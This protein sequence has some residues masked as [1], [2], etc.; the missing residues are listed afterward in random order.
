MQ[1]QYVFWLVV[2]LLIQACTGPQQSPATADK[3]T[4]KPNIVIIFTD[5]QGYA[6][7]QSFGGIQLVTP[8][9][10]R[11]AAEG[12]KLT[13]FYVAQPVCSASRAALLTGSYPNRVG[14]S[15]AFMPESGKGLNLAETTLA[16][17]LQQAGYVTGHVGKWHLGDDPT[18][19]PNRQG[20]DEFF[21]IP[22][23]NDMWP[24]HPLQ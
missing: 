4:R 11:M 1:R 15:G 12:V 22:H 23:S 20:F 18:F 9:L 3:Q 10:D 14:V 17:L 13:N 21:G 7:V 24:H 19:M 2:V 5:D 6:D 16:E 8:N